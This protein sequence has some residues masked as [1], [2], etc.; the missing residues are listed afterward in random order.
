MNRES[1]LSAHKHRYDWPLHRA[2]SRSSIVVKTGRHRAVLPPAMAAALAL[3]V[4]SL[5]QSV[6]LHGWCQGHTCE[7]QGEAGG[8]GRTLS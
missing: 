8:A 6:D 3:H 7:A 4:S 2:L 5:H 1:R